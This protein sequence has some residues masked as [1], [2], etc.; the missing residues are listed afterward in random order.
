MARIPETDIAL[1]PAGPGPRNLQMRLREAIS[2]AIWEGRFAPGDR[3]P[4]TRALAAHLGLARITVA[5]AYDDLATDGWLRAAPRSGHFVAE[6]APRRL[7]APPPP[8]AGARALDWAARLGPPPPALGG[9]AK[10]ADWRGFPYPF[11]FGQADLDGFPMDEWRACARAALGR[12]AFDVVAGDFGDRDDPMLT[13]QIA[14]RVLPARG[15][16]AGPDEVL[17]CYG[18]QN[19]LWVAAELLVSGRPGAL[20]AVEDPGWPETRHMLARLGARVVPVPVDADGID[21]EAIPAE[22]AVVFVTPGHHAPTGAA[23]SEPRRARL[24]E[25]AVAHDWI[26][27]EDDYDFETSYLRPAA[28]A[29]KARDRTG[30]V[31]LVGSF[32]KTL[33]PGLRLGYLHAPAAFLRHARAVRTLAARH[34]PGLTQRAAAH[35]LALGHYNAHAAAIR[36]RLARRRAALTAALADHG[37]PAPSDAGFGGAAIWLEGPPDLDADRLAAALRPRGVLIEPGRPFFAAADPPRNFLRL[38]FSVMPEPRIAPGV[39]LIAEEWRR[40]R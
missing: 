34:P 1:A 39:A 27:V 19:A 8:G 30:R 15:L 10:P 21:P 13:A 23:L 14:A 24:L 17:V 28:P 40:L 2:A 18:A 12:A 33:F 4:A 7:P 37:L 9:Q 3:L 31:I 35:F 11:V 36:R 22:T 29:L 38:G 26:I 20:A 25:R 5:L 16:R 32:S 6:D